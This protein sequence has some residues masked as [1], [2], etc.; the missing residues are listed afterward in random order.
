MTELLEA[1]AESDGFLGESVEEWCQLPWDRVFEAPPAPDASE[2]DADSPG[3]RAGERLGAYRLVRRVGRGGMA[4]VYLAERADGQFERRVAVKLLR[5]GLDTD[6]IVRRFLAERQILSSLSHPN[7]AHVLDGGVTSGGLPYFVMEYV[8]G[9]PIDVWCDRHGAD[10]RERLRLFCDV[11]RAVHHAHRSLVVHRDLKPSNILV[12]ESGTVKLLDFGIAK[13]LAD[14]AGGEATRTGM[15][16]M[17]PAYASPEQVR[18]DPITTASDVYQLGLVLSRLLCGRVPYDVAA[19]SPARAE[20]LV[21]EADPARP[22]TLVTDEAAAARGTN[23]R[24]LARALTG[25][26]DLIVL[27]SLRREPEQRFSSA[28]AMV[29]DLQRHVRGEPV[30]AR[31]DAIS[32]RVSK[33]VGRNRAAVA[34]AAALFL[35]VLGSAIFASVQARRLAIERDRA[36][37]H[38]TRAAQVTAFLTEMFR[39]TDPNEGAAD[40]AGAVA[41]LERGVERAMTELGPNPQVEADVLGAI[42]DMYLAR[43]LNASAEPVLVRA[44]ALRRG[45]ATGEA[46]ADPEGLVSDLIRLARARALE[47]P[48]AAARLLEEAVEVAEGEL[49]PSHL[50]LAIALREYAEI[51]AVGPGV[52][53]AVERALEIVRAPEHEGSAELASILHLSA[54]GHGVDR[55]D[56]LE[57]A[58]EI[59]RE[60]YGED[61][62]VVALTLNDMALALEPFDPLAADT[63]LERAAEINTRIH[64]PNHI[65]TITILNNLAGRYR[66]RGDC[67]KAEPLYRELLARRLE[68][69]PGD[70]GGIIFTKHGLGWCLSEL[71]RAADAEPLLREVV[72]Y[73]ADGPEIIHQV[74]RSTLGRSLA[75]QRRFDE[76]EPL[77][78]ESYE[79]VDAN[80]P[81][82][83]FM[84]ILLGRVI[85]LFAETGREALAEEYRVRLRVYEEELGTSS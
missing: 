85:D 45:L 63:L 84:P 13:L 82:P 77:I 20:R 38:E 36:V 60:I 12:D 4:D 5:R 42:G 17:T 79:W 24:D 33:F 41:L 47:D 62:T 22:S 69:Y 43:G 74:A 1:E 48:D 7:I 71:G 23:A 40:S 81:I 6:D 75:K 66:D 37:A 16:A 19:L 29:D 80:D 58:L 46:D 64:G 76:A 30:T 50:G 14:E 31:P 51:V 18:G 59:R 25:D 57:E 3:R 39:I 78:L 21:T 28:Q 9:T 2:G 55:F 73:A 35:V 27:Q 10:L 53:E 67:E 61:H 34:I 72:D 54:L 65:Q 49:G 56:R 83:I 26:L 44:L 32:Y 15:R 68:A 52:E 70:I 8:E 11:G